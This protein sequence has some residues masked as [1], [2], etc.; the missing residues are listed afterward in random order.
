VGG[1]SRSSSSS[2]SSSSGSWTDIGST[3]VGA[4]AQQQAAD[5][6]QHLVA[7]VVKMLQHLSV[8][9]AGWQQQR[10][11]HQSHARILLVIGV[12]TDLQHYKTGQAAATANM[13]QPWVA[14]A[15]AAAVEGAFV[16]SSVDGINTREV[17]A[18]RTAGHE[19]PLHPASVPRCSSTWLQHVV[20]AS[21]RPGW[22][23]ECTCICS[24]CWCRWSSSAA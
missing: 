2:S 7:A 23:R 17:G 20:H 4:A 21:S 16:S 18:T 22:M 11:Q 10:Q 9:S 8:V 6:H 24:R 1:A 13:N 12:E 14:Q 3:P 19:A 15:A 5:V